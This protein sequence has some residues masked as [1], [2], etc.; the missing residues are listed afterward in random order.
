ML[1]KLQQVSAEDIQAV[2]RKYFR[3]DTL[4]IGVLDPQPLAP[5]ARR[6]A[7]AGSRH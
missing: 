4:T 6:P 2:A 1:D 7:H 3:D 5:A